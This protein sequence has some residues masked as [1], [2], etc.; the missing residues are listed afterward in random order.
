MLTYPVGLGGAP[1]YLVDLALCGGVGKDGILYGAGHLLD[2]PDE[3]LMVISG[4]ADVAGGV[5]RPGDAVHARP[6]VVQ[7]AQNTQVIF[8][9]I[10]YGT[11]R[12]KLGCRME[13]KGTVA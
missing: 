9:P 2:V 1:L 12:R 7:P 10:R 13:L 8:N 3:R 11:Y 6:V 5:G 4:R